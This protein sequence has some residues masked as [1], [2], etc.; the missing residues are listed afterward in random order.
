MNKQTDIPLVE[1]DIVTDLLSMLNK[2]E[3]WRPNIERALTHS[4]HS[5]SFN[6]IAIRTLQQELQFWDFGDCYCFTEIMVFP[7]YKN[8][9][10][11]V[12]GGN[13]ESMFK[14]RDA[15]MELAKAN[16]CKHLSCS[17]RPGWARALKS[18]GWKH[19]LTTMYMEVK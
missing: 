15:F 4:L 8:L 13:M 3:K 6:D 5:Y 9:H 2:M 18:Q 10:F 14:H 19:M 1:G 16:G 7:Q 12:A 17:G 11:M